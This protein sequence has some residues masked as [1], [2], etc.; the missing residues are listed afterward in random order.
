M[1]ICTKRTSALLSLLAVTALS[2]TGC[3]VLSYSS[4]TGER[5]T[6]GCLGGNTSVAS[7]A[8]ET[9]TNGL[10]RVELQGYR[11][12]STQALS[13]VTEAAVRAALQAR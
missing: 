10:R 11:N 8:I 2:T 3:T 13:T 4:P 6:R 12:D 1:R 5:L 7:L 9:G